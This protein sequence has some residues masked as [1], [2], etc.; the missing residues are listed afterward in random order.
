MGYD[1]E[2]CE[3][4]LPA[5]ISTGAGAA[6][7]VAATSGAALT[8]A[9]GGAAGATGYFA[10]AGVLLAHAG[11]EAAAMVGLGTILAGPLLGG[12]A[13]YGIYRGVRKITKGQ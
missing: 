12:L 10:G 4:K 3:S 1:K 6:A 11:C 7:G 9:G 13:G 8:A 2:Q 5:T